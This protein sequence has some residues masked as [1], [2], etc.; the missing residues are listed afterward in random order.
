MLMPLTLRVLLEDIAGGP[1]EMNERADET[2]GAMPLAR[3]APTT[4]LMLRV[5]RPPPDW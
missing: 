4:A 3:N 2:I 5:V 1:L